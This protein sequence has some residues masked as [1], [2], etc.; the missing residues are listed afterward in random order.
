MFHRDFDM[1]VGQEELFIAD[2]APLARSLGALEA[3]GFARGGD[4]AQLD[5]VRGGL[6]RAFLDALTSN[7]DDVEIVSECD[8]RYTNFILAF[9]LR[10]HDMH[11][12][13]EKLWIDKY[14][15]VS[16][17]AAQDVIRVSF[18]ESNTAEQV[19]RAVTALSQVARSLEG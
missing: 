8:D 4:F 15:M 3:A 2:V 13:V 9:R 6:K 18:A 11:R 10:E 5:S 19:D 7:L 17:I 1:P 16:Y 14:V 12:V